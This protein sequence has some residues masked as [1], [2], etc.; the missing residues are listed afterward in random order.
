M[1]YVWILALVFVFVGCGENKKEEKKG[2]SYERTK[3]KEEKKEETI[4]VP[5]DLN[6]KG[7]GPIKELS[8]PE[9]ID[10]DLADKGKVLFMEKCTAC[11]LPNKKLVG[12]PMQGVYKQ[13]SPEWVMN[14]IMNPIE[15]LKK[16]SI[17]Q[18]L[19]K[20]YNNAVMIDQRIGEEDARALAEY[21]RTL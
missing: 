15:M 16:D 17:A 8:F 18:A 11:H 1:K 7:V 14:M 3:K 13:R 5:V 10:T 12:P 21:L 19:Q 9:T 4:E 6:N 20:Q 2:F